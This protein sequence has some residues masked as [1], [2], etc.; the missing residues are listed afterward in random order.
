MAAI[1]ERRGLNERLVQDGRLLVTFCRGA[2][3][4]P[5]NLAVRF[6]DLVIPRGRQVSRIRVCGWPGRSAIVRN[7]Q[8]RSY[9]D[10]GGDET[11][12]QQQ[13]LKVLVGWRIV[14]KSKKI[15]G[16]ISSNPSFG[17]WSVGS[18]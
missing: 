15:M 13:L 17:R 6:R 18:R 8:L 1:N 4:W 5:R 14:G 12:E 10:D 9:A 2:G 3:G 11:M 7:R 16:T